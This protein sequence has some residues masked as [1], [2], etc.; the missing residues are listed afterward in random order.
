ME[1]FPLDIEKLIFNYTYG[2]EHYDKF[3]H[4][5]KEIKKIQYKEY[6]DSY[7]E[8]IS[9]LIRDGKMSYYRIVNYIG[10]EA[11]NSLVNSHKFRKYWYFKNNRLEEYDEAKS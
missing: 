2:A 6:R 8:H 4:C 5:L 1:I 7:G 11:E 10:F 3:K 9:E